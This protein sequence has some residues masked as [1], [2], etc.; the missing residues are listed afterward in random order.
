MDRD[1]RHF[2]GAQYEDG[3]PE[4]HV[5]ARLHST[6]LGH[7]ASDFTPQRGDHDDPY[8]VLTADGQR[9]IGD[10]ELTELGREVDL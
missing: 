4:Q 10:Y 1:R 7:S 2:T 6:G 3:A 5:A 9:A 8:F